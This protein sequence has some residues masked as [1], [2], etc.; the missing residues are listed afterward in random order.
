MIEKE[1]AEIAREIQRAEGELETGKRPDRHGTRR[2]KRRW[3]SSRS[4][5][6]R[7]SAKAICSAWRRFATGLLVQTEEEL[8][9]AHRRRWRRPAAQAH[10]ERRSGR[11]RRRPHRLQVD[12]DSGLEDAGRRSQEA[13]HHG[14][15]AAPARG[16]PG[17]GPGTR[18]ERH[19]PIARGAERSQAADR[20]VHLPGTD[21][22]GQDRTGA[23]AGRI[24]VRRR[25]R[26]GAH[27]HV[28]VHG[29]ARRLAVDRR[30]SRATSATKKADS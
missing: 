29:E 30:A 19:S 16:G 12:R 4:K 13:G 14:R 17:R 6:R 21:R 11:R 5:S 1:L 3:S 10:A 23:R 27:R 9:E 22:R 7:K 15:A 2:S 18:G 24:P 20:L 25:A 8:Q 26:H 28:R